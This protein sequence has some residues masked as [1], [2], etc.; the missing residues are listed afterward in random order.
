MEFDEMKAAWKSATAV[1]KTNEEIS[2][3]IREYRHPVLKG[4]RKQT[5]MEFAGWSA[6]LICYYSMFDGDK[7]PGFINLILIAVVMISLLHNLYSYTLAKNLVAGSNLS[8][9]L[10]VY[11]KKI[12]VFRNCSLAARALLMM[13]LILFFT[14][15]THFTTIKYESLAGL[16]L[17]FLCLL[18][19]LYRT[20]TNRLKKLRQTL[21]AMND[22]D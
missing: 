20:W 19:L 12:A 11:I 14:Y 3:M 18:W 21:A 15:G 10:A 1:P 7:K 22:E 8:A 16:C 2:S 6:F 5:A 17:V 4:I 13:G 9:S